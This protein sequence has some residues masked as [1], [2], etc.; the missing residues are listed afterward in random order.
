MRPAAANSGKPPPT[1]A[2][3]LPASVISRRVIGVHPEAPTAVDHDLASRLLAATRPYE[4]HREPRAPA[5]RA[6]R[7]L[8][9][10]S[11]TGTST[12]WCTSAARCDAVRVAMRCDMLPRMR[13]EDARPRF[14]T[15]AGSRSGQ[16]RSALCR[17]M[18]RERRLLA[19]D[20]SGWPD[21]IPQKRHEQV[22]GRGERSLGRRRSRCRQALAR[23]R[24]VSRPRPHA[25]RR[26]PR[27]SGK[28]KPPPESGGFLRRSGGSLRLSGHRG[29]EA[30]HSEGG[31]PLGS[32]LP[33][34]VASILHIRSH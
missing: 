33:S 3:T 1:L 24:G 27:C 5:R 21:D 4:T 22:R 30:A 11:G 8:R 25:A 18:E 6:R 17:G 15:T 13:A 26:G 7:P 14:A 23:R 10:G 28:G 19:Q 34:R 9:R 20:M 32:V 31:D 29:E 12:K 16:T 2:A